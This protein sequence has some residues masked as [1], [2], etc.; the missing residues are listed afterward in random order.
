MKKEQ[1]K[2][3]LK[4]GKLE[5]HQEGAISTECRILY[6]GIEIHPMS[7]QLNMKAG[8]ISTVCFEVLAS[9]IDVS[10]EGLQGFIEE[11]IT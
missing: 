1:D 11:K 10:L 8:E 3:I 4:I 5:I 6:D 9:D 7:L 2:H